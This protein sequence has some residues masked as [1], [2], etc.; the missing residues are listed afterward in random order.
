MKTK[1]NLTIVLT[2]VLS[3]AAIGTTAWAGTGT[4]PGPDSK[5]CGLIGTWSG[6]ADYAW[7]TSST[8][9]TPSIAWLG[10]HTAGS[11]NAKNGEM[12]LNWVFVNGNLLTLYGH[13][14]ASHLTP[15]HGVWEQINNNQYSYTWYAYGLDASGSPLYSVKVSGLVTNM[16]CDNASITYKYEV[17]N[18][19]VSPQNM[20]SSPYAT[21]LGIAGET[22]V[23][24][25]P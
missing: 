4:G 15:G 19:L 10:I 3:I 18:G 8:A 14:P 17:F 16:N 20:S 1:R 13:Y 21:K 6:W 9:P 5:E 7:P 11:Q 12:L 23:P 22:R 2:T 24:L 25:T